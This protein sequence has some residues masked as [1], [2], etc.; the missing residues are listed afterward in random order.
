MLNSI[1]YDKIKIIFIIGENMLHIKKVL[2]ILF[3]ILIISSCLTVSVSAQ[4]ESLNEIYN[5]PYGRTMIASRKG[6]WKEAPENSL[7]AIKA[8]ENIGADIIEI[9]VKKTADGVLILMAD[10]TVERTCYGYGEKTVVSEMTYDEISK[11]KLLEGEGGPKTE[12]T[13]ETVPTLEEVFKNKKLSYLASSAL[14]TD[15]SLLMLDA[16]FEDRNEIYNLAKEQNMTAS[17]IFL[18]TDAKPDDI[19]EWK[20]EINDNVMT[21]SYFKGNVIFSALSFMTKAEKAGNESVYLATSNPY[22]VIFGETVTGKA[23]GKMRMMANAAE[24]ELSGKVRKDTEVWWDDLISRGYSIILTDYPAELKAYIDDCEEKIGA[25]EETYK[26]TVSD[27]QLPDF[28]SDKFYD[29]KL[30]YTNAKELAESL[31]KDKSSARS[32]IVTATYD[33]Q[34]AYDDI[35]NNYDELAQGTAGM[36]VT[37][38]RILLCIAAVAVVVIAEIYVYRQKKK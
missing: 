20:T 16:S 25:L 38:V 14:H 1:L 13:E 8:A 34:K 24:S 27:W 6:Y 28:N 37:P 17:V 32:T 29:Y 19:A 31:L 5:D 12:K 2:F 18:F 22:G 9:D 21:M 7:K 26:K 35:N 36:T 33:L 10:E 4:E 30:A 15:F 3:S 11:L 23:D